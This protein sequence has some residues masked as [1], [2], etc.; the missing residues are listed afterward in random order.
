MC[1]AGRNLGVIMRSL[2]GMGKP[3]TLQ[4]EGG[5]GF[6]LTWATIV[7]VGL[8]FRSLCDSVTRHIGL[9]ESSVSKLVAYRV[10]FNARRNL[11]A[12]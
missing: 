4:A 11:N 7:A 1:V 8:G 10:G 5:G 2:F 9:A 6:V 12:A 3:K